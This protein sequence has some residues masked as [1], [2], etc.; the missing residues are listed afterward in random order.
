MILNAIVA[1]DKN[2]AIG[3]TKRENVNVSIPWR[4]SKEFEYFMRMCDHMKGDSNKK[5]TMLVCG[6]KVHQEHYTCTPKGM[7]EFYYVVVSKSIKE[8]PVN[9]HILTDDYSFNG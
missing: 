9:C 5:R 6:P 2:N 4:L 1:A 3:N 7:E 8:K